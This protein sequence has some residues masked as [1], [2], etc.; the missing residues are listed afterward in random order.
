[1]C[2]L[3]LWTK[4]DD[5]NGCSNIEKA[6]GKIVG[7]CFYPIIANTLGSNNNCSFIYAIDVHP[8]ELS[9][10]CDYLKSIQNTP[11]GRFLYSTCEGIPR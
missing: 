10:V 7:L 8:N 6:I 1:M 11:K 9:Y 4:A 2:N 5:I 3:I